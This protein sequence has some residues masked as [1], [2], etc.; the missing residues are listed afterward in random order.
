MKGFTTRWI[1]LIIV[2][3]LSLEMLNAAALPWTK[4]HSGIEHGAAARPAASACRSGRV[5]WDNSGSGGGTAIT[6]QMWDHSGRAQQ[7]SQAWGESG[8]E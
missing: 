4:S 5:E 7:L 6:T 3:M 2:S 1:V 8:R